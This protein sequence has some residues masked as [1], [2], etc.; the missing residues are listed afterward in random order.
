MQRQL[1]NHLCRRNIAEEATRSRDFPNISEKQCNHW[2]PDHVFHLITIISEFLT[3][4]VGFREAIITIV[5]FTYHMSVSI[6]QE[7]RNAFTSVCK[8]DARPFFSFVSVRAITW[9]LGNTASVSRLSL[10][11]R[12][13]THIWRKKTKKWW[14][15]NGKD[16]E[17][18]K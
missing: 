15:G 12:P 1:S 8:S 14:K 6:A 9:L 4:H 2:I 16:E 7:P 10:K 13:M 18:Q 5:R 11:V 17:R 3:A